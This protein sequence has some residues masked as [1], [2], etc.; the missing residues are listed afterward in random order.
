M[1]KECFFIIY[2]FYF[3]FVRIIS[4]FLYNYQEKLDFY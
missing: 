2:P 4:Y 1:F 3:D